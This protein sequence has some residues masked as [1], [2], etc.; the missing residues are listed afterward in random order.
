MN[1]LIKKTL[2]GDAKEALFQYISHMDLKQSTKLPAETAL[3]EQLGVSRVTVRR[4]IDELECSGI[5]LR[6]H[7]RGTFVNPNAVQISV[8]LNTLCGF[9]DIIKNSGH[10]AN[11]QQLCCIKEKAGC[12]AMPLGLHPNEI[13][14]HI[15]TL[16]TADSNPA[17]LTSA[18]FAEHLLPAMK[19][20]SMCEQS[21]I[22]EFLYH[23]SGLLMSSDKLRVC[24][25]S[26]QEAA[27][28]FPN[29]SMLH[30]DALLMLDGI[31]FDQNNQPLFYG[32][33]FY[34]TSIIQFDIFR[35]R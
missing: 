28:Q 5:L 22:P 26:R 29:I 21:S 25:C 27:A 2:A 15:E 32:F 10:A 12:H 13:V 11:S 34:D 4:A 3:A 31:A 16:Y 18:F 23:N 7:G 24:A 8:N 9:G 17:I 30:A 1:T 33:S 6:Q 20:P 19:N 14:W 35:R